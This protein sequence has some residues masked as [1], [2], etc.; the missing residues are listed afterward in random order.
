[1]SYPAV[2]QLIGRVGART[3]ISFTAHMLRHTHATDMVRQGVPIEVVARL[4]THRSSTTTSQ[5]Y[6]H[7]EA[8]DIRE[9]LSRAGVWQRTERPAMSPASAATRAQATGPQCGGCARAQAWTASGPSTTGTPAASGVPARRGRGAARFDTDHPGL[10]ARAGQALVPVPPRHRVRLL[11]HFCRGTGAVPVLRFLA[12]RHPERDRRGRHHPAGAGGL[13]GLAAGP[14]LL[15]VHP[16]AVAVDAPG[17]LR[18]LPPPRLAARAGRQRHHL[19]RRAPLPPRR[20]GPVHPRVRHGP[21]RVRRRLWPR[22]RTPP[23]ATWSW[24]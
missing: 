24:C 1:M 8:A 11:D 9:A 17:V 6:V 18:R 4:L 22:S 19:R 5:T 2:H 15:G 23:P 16:G 21:A 20:D 10:A 3:G 14:G 12:E 13:P 7:L